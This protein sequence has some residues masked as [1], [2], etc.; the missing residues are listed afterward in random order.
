MESERL[1]LVWI[2]LGHRTGDNQQL[3]A[4][5][6]ALGWPRVAKA[7]AY[8]R[9]LVGWTPLYPAIPSLGVLTREARA[10]IEGP[11]PDLVLSIG[12]R[13][14][15]VARWI[16]RASGGR[17][18]LV[19]IGRPRA[20]FDLFDL[21]VTTPQ[22]RMPEADNVL[23]LTAPVTQLDAE[24]LRLAR[25]RWEGRLAHLPRP[26]I[27]VLAG[28]DAPPYRFDAAA[29]RRLRDEAQALARRQ[30]GSLLVATSPRT[31]PPAAGILCADITV[32]HHCYMWQAGGHDNPYLAYLALADE[33]V[34]TAESVSMMHD[35]SQTGRAL[36]LFDVPRAGHHLLNALSWIDEAARAGHGK[37]GWAGIYAS[38][39]RAGLIYPPR[40]V[41]D[42]QRMLIDDGRAVWL[43]GAP[44]F[45]PSSAP[46][47][48]ARALAAI[49]AL[50]E[51]GNTPSC[52]DAGR[53][54]QQRGRSVDEL[55]NH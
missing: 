46:D 51:A 38:L 33:I 37:R 49:R 50:F 54:A 22:Y 27:A 19:H 42:V 41:G 8:R 45:P 15:P 48:R 35:A 6:A 4:L 1:P 39:L 18:R 43:G 20:R 16:R 29:A 14:V 9:R 23:H 28:G 17:A 7:L 5:G 21:I 34:V 31:A 47:Q 2:L 10:Q 52:G 40:V 32:P 24:Q 53:L 13:A 44:P 26:W 25:E 11:W 36:H 12:W 30:G 3:E 55:R